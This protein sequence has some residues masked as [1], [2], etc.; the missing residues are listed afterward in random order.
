MIYQE[1][2][3]T[4]EECDKI[5]SYRFDYPNHIVT[6]NWSMIEGTRTVYLQV[7]NLN[8]YKKY[9]VW[10][11]PIDSN[12]SWFYEKI[13]S[14]FEN[15]SG[16]TLDRIHFNKSYAAH[17][18]HEYNV[19]DKFGIH[20]DN[21]GDDFKDRV[22]NLG[23]NLNSDFDGGE[24]IC[25]SLDYSEKTILEKISGNAVAYTSDVP[26]EI[27]KITEGSRYSMVIKILEDE[28]IN[29]SKKTLI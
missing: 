20:V 21:N 10:D 16:L 17:K 12:T 19:G 3:F 7:E 4:Q 25:Y 2:I 15:I 23:I 26:H 5:L 29:K 8:W 22:W 18:L 24:Y 6:P 9:N 13:Y 28:I 27:T 1:K 11:I 14:W